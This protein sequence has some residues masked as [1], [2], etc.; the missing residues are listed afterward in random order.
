MSRINHLIQ[1]TR[2]DELR[3]LPHGWA[4]NGQ[5]EAIDPTIIEAAICLLRSC[6]HAGT[7]EP[8]IFPTEEG[9][10]RFQWSQNVTPWTTVFYIEMDGIR[11]SKI[12]DDK[13][14]SIDFPVSQIE[15]AANSID[16]FLF[17]AQ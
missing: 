3:A 9:E 13:V 17:Y 10:I 1:Q 12:V 8:S 15:E 2:I 5:G 4:G 16:G 14:V 6:V 11:F 7:P